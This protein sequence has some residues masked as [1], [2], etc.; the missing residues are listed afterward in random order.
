MSASAVKSSERVHCCV[1]SACLRAEISEASRSA[2]ATRRQQ[3]PA[4]DGQT[5]GSGAHLR[6]NR[7]AWMEECTGWK[8]HSNEILTSSFANSALQTFNFR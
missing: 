4:I 5:G 6:S 1:A 3:A 8:F 7:L 2:G